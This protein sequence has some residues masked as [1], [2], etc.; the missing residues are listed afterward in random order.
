MSKPQKSVRERVFDYMKKNK[1]KW[2]TVHQVR[3]ALKLSHAAVSRALRDETE[4]GRVERKKEATGEFRS[5]GP[6]LPKNTPISAYL[7]RYKRATVKKGK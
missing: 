1:T 7:Y 5:Q 3:K 4:D 2:L 6:G